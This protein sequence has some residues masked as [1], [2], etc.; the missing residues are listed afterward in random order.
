VRELARRVPCDHSHLSKLAHGDKGASEQLAARL[1]RV[2]DA[3]G[4]LAALAEPPARK[5]KREEPHGETPRADGHGLSLSLPFVPGR[6]VIEISDPAADAS[7]ARADAASGQLALV[8][9]LPARAR[10]DTGR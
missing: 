2:L 5:D 7:Q 3:G 6:L 10:Q 4:E 9:E 1:D 8:R